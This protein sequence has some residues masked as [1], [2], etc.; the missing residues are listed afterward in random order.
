MF[1]DISVLSTLLIEVN[2]LDDSGERFANSAGAVF[3]WRECEH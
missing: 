2:K 3:E 1:I